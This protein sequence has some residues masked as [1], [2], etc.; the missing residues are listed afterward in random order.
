MGVGV[1]VG[2]GLERVGGNQWAG[3]DNQS[4]SIMP[5]ARW[6]LIIVNLEGVL[7]EVH[8]D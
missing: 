8:A 6:D 4:Y 3:N 5:V 7:S 1:W 2:Y